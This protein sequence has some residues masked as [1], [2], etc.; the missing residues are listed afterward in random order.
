MSNLVEFQESERSPV[1]LQAST[2]HGISSLA[3]S[4]D[5]ILSA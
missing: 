2:G 5:C 1:G 4:V 3:T